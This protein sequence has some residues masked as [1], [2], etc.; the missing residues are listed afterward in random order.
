MFC[1]LLYEVIYISKIY[2]RVFQ[3]VYIYIYTVYISETYGKIS[4]SSYSNNSFLKGT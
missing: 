2:G 1:I 4:Q 3:S